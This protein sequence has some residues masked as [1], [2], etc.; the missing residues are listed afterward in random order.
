M[1]ASLWM[2]CVLFATGSMN[3]GVLELRLEGPLKAVHLD[4]VRVPTRVVVDLAPA[5]TIT[6]RVPWLPVDPEAGP[7]LRFVDGDGSAR[8][9]A[10]HP[11]PS[12]APV[13]VTRRPLPR[14][15]ETP[16][17]IPPVAWWLFAGGLFA[18]FAAR[19]R[20]MGAAIVGAM[21][22]VVLTVLP[23]AEAERPTVAVLEVGSFGAWWVYVGV[24]ELEP[25]LGAHPALETRPEG[26]NWEW[27][28]DLSDPARSREF[29]R[30]SEETS[31]IA[32]A[33]GPL[34]VSLSEEANGFEALGEL[35]RRSPQGDWTR[36]GV[37]DL[38]APLPAAREGGLLPTW[39]RAGASPG[40]EV[41]V[42]RLAEAPGVAQEAWV[43]IISPAGK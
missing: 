29:G 30:A 27:L 20:P 42:G 40:A 1:T 7:A 33:P 2:L 9:E 35:W 38:G 25:P 10:V 31:L 6:V 32:R 5:E 39:L 16:P 4:D 23:Q 15:V 8:V 12:S 41:W 24:G 26:A 36:H 11:A 13:A 28:V 18:V 17:R 21:F 43:R 14:S 37:W 34:E 22:G 3:D 19:R